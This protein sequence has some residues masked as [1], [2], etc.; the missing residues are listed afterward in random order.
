GGCYYYSI[1]DAGR[2]RELLAIDLKD[3]ALQ[4]TTSSLLPLMGLGNSVGFPTLPRE[5]HY[6]KEQQAFVDIAK[7]EISLNYGGATI[8]F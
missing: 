2:Y 8:D 3:R 4:T 6:I 7:Y 1:Q 5:D